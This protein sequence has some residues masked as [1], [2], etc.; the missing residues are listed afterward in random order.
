MYSVI[1]RTEL[2][3][4]REIQVAAGEETGKVERNFDEPWEDKGFIR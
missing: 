2:G 4:K 3:G 1:L